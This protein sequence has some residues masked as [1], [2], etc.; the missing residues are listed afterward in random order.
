MLAA[1]GSLQVTR[2]SLFTHINDPDVCQAMAAELF[3]K[4]SSGA[5]VARIDQRFDLTDVA[6][7]HRALESRQTTGATILTIA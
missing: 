4:I 1:K 3:E 6:A 7:A 2:P 5:I